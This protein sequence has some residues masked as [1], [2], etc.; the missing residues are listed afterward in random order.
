M[1]KMSFS[2]HIKNLI[3]EEKYSGKSVN[4]R[5][6][7]DLGFFVVKNAF[8]LNTVKKYHFNFL[9][10]FK[11][12]KLSKTKQHPVEVKIE[13]IKFFQKIYKDKNLKKISKGFFKG[14]VGS[15]FYRI[16]KKDI[17]NS[18]AV[19]CHQDTGYQVGSFDRYSLF[20]CLT[21]NNHLNGGMVVYPATHKFGYLGDAGEISKNISKKYLKICPDLKVGDV[22]VM[23]SAL[24]HESD[25][26]F[27]KS[28]RIYLEIHIQNIDE[29]TTK[30][31]ILGSRNKILKPLFQKNNIFSNSRVS[32]IISFK[33]KIR[34]L[35][36]KLSR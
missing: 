22:L 25:K 3:N 2:K 8:P 16:V 27:T 18:S 23:H 36:K 5:K 9:K 33:K 32:R 11:K 10:F 14:R 26:N 21:D 20:I 7:D 4:H 31:N 34:L 35:E 6:L 29:P 12:K 13:K 15:D 17:R 30:Y 24:W 1:N 28:N 19:F